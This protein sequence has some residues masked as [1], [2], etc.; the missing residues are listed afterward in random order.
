MKPHTM[1]C[2][3]HVPSSVMR[4]DMVTSVLS[5][6]NLRNSSMISEVSWSEMHHDIGWP[7]VDNNMKW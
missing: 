5:C 2:I 3:T 1:S 6:M 7:E 4:T